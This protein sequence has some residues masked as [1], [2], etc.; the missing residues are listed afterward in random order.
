MEVRKFNKQRGVGEYKWRNKTEETDRAQ[1]VGESI[2]R[3]CSYVES[4]RCADL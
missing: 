4:K 1:A 2:M 3:N